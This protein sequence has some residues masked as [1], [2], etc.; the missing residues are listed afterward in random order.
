MR[1]R[2][3]LNVSLDELKTLVE[4]EE[5]RKVLRAEVQAGVDDPERLRLLLNEALGH[6]DSQLALV[7]R[8]TSELRGL[9]VDLEER[10]SKVK[11][12]L[13]GLARG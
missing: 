1:L 8:R 4:A 2:S 11:A 6:L 3:L 9:E 13:R 7:R 12:R 10:R 5:A